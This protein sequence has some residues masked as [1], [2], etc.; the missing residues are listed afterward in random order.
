MS[1][2][3]F[4]EGR[5]QVTETVTPVGM[6]RSG[7][8]ASDSGNTS[9]IV[10]HP[11][12]TEEDFKTQ[13]WIEEH[14]TYAY[15]DEGVKSHFG[16][17]G[18]GQAGLTIGMLVPRGKTAYQ[19]MIEHNV[20]T[21]EL[22]YALADYPETV[23]ALWQAMMQNNLDAA[24]LSAECPELDYFLTWEDSSTQNYSPT[25]YRKY[26]MPEITA[27]CDILAANGKYYIQH[28]CGH[29]KEL[30]QPMMECGVFAVESLSAAP[31]GNVEVG[32]ARAQIGAGMGI[33]GGIEPVHFLD[34][35]ITELEAYVEQ[36]LAE[37]AGGPFVLANSDSCPPGVTVEK[38]KLV[39]DVLKRVRV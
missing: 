33:I 5:L 4:S 31:T 23:E 30:L 39:A 36:I 12:K 20:G 1:Y 24:R 26:I 3:E 28:A 7:R 13:L 8:I 29:V 27:Y 16:K 38:Y 22:N 15:N 18:W 35:S 14:T 34:L 9:F 21:E 17:D 37:G 2:R 32:E 25:Q 6:L 19:I 10:E 11:L